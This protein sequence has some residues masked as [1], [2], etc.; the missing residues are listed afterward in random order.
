M[1]QRFSVI[2]LSY[3]NSQYLRGCIDSVIMQNYY[4]IEIIIADDGTENF[5][6]MFFERY[7]LEKRRENISRVLVYKN[8]KNLGTVKSV[9]K[10]ISYCEGSYFKIIGG[11]DELADENSLSNAAAA[12][13]RSPDGIICCDVIKCDSMMRV[14]GPYTKGLQKK[15]NDLSPRECFKHLCIHNDIPAGGVFLNKNFMRRFAPY[16][17]SY[18]LLEDWPMWLKVT[19]DGARI[20]YISFPGVK[21]RADVGFGTSVNPTYMADKKLVLEKE[22]IQRKMDLGFV[23]YIKARVSFMIINN[24]YV[25]RLYGLIFRKEDSK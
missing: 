9:N 14:I 16:D 6:P 3:N 22:I 17:E 1:S 24:S 20:L 19:H 10:A 25:R 7:C 8:E 18:R 2:I 15:L 21:Y 11:D 13:D 23:T 4:D 5:D 12:L